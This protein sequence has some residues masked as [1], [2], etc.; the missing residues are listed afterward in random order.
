MR[1]STCLIAA[2]LLGTMSQAQQTLQV[3]GV[4]R[5]VYTHIGALRAPSTAGSTVCFD[6]IQRWVGDGSKRAALVIKWND[7]KDGNAKLVWGYRWEEDSQATGE[8]MVRAV[9]AADPAFCALIYAGTQ[10]GST[11]GGMGYDIDGNG[12]SSLLLGKTTCPVRFGVCAASGYNFDDYSSPDTLDHWKSGWSN[13][14]WSYWIAGGEK[15]KFGQSGQGAS[16]RKLTDGC[17]DG[18]SFANDM[19]NPFSADM[20]GVNKYLPEIKA[21]YTEGTFIVNEDWYGHQNSTVNF[22]SK[23]GQW[24]Y[25]IVQKAN[26]GMQLGCTNQFGAIYGDKFYL[27]SK[28]AQDPGA[29]IKG[30]R[31]NV[32]DIKTMRLLK[33]HEFIATDKS[34]ESI[35]DGR[36]FLGV[37]DSKGYV[38]TSNGIYILNLHTLD[39]MGA[40]AGTGND[41]TDSYSQLY[42]GQI[43]TMVRVGERVFACHQKKGLLVINANT[44]SVVRTLTL[45]GGWGPGSIIL[46]KDGNLWLSVADPAGMGDAAPYIYKIDPASLDTT[47]VDMPEG[48]YPPANSWYAWT[49]DCFC[50][51]TQNNVIYWNGGPNSWFSNKAIF[52]YDIDQNSFAT[53]IDLSNEDWQVYGSSFRV[54][55]VTDEAYVSFNKDFSDPTYIVRR[56]SNGG[57][58]LAEYSM[59]QNFWFPSLPVFPDKAAPQSAITSAL[60]HIGTE[61]FLYSLDGF[62]ADSDNIT[63]SIVVTVKSISDPTVLKAHIA[64]GNLIVTPLADGNATITLRINSNGKILDTDMAVAIRLQTGLHDGSTA[65]MRV[66]NVKDGMFHA[67]GCEGFLFRVY[68]LAGRAQAQYAADSDNYSQPSGLTPGTYIVSGVRGAEKLSFK[69][70]VRQN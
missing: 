41:A 57:T 15:E 61:T 6:S 20:T 26:P 35:A 66:V 52:K 1:K 31:I 5:N 30:G 24:T 19:S 46:S 55:P 39:V 25:R 64:N 16:S 8:A 63:A 38:G 27:I 34:G 23:D 21:L 40:I 37:D 2:L 4:P 44:D 49:P 65:S 7:G 36:A 13:G 70:A 33:Q 53:Y 47:R 67:T 42:G 3:Q 62:V 54:D 10:Y 68:D 59:I 18:W 11:I 48:I 22:L 12:I 69:I 43:G 50:A 28:Q 56:Y 17:V 9:A 60:E 29:S 45:P 58:R 51:S 14:F 32:C